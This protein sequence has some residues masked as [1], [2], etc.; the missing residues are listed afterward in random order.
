MCASVKWVRR[1]GCAGP[2]RQRCGR[3]PAHSRCAGNVQSQ[4]H[5]GQRGRRVRLRE[6]A[7]AAASGLRAVRGSGPAPGRAGQPAPRPCLGSGNRQ[8]EPRAGRCCN[9]GG[10]RAGVPGQGRRLGPRAPPGKKKRLRSG[11]RD[12]RW[13]PGQ[14]TAGREGGPGGDCAPRRGLSGEAGYVLANGRPRRVR[15]HPQGEPIGPREAL[16][17]G[18]LGPSNPAPRSLAAVLLLV[19]PNMGAPRVAVRG[20]AQAS[21][22]LRHASLGSPRL[23]RARAVRKSSVSHS[24]AT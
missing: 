4:Q 15:P 2:A 7:P 8:K 20:H 22:V 17:V 12:R 6:P 10:R 13:N 21:S 24:E 3:R 5:P 23:I 11:H 14:G 16:G 18:P 1:N 19:L 9:I